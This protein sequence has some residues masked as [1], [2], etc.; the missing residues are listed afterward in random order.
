MAKL[1]HLLVAGRQLNGN[2]ELLWNVIGDEQVD[3]DIQPGFPLKDLTKPENFLSL[4]HY[5]GLLSIRDV[6]VSSVN[7]FRF[8]QLMMAMANRGEWRPVL[9]FLSEAIARQTGIR[10]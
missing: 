5:F 9:E 7:L 6:E 3:T 8:E 2:F 10:D 4:L 1:R